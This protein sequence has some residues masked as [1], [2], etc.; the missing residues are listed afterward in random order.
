MTTTEDLPS[1]AATPASTPGL[2]SLARDPSHNPADHIAA[3]TYER[4]TEATGKRTRP[5]GIRLTNQLGITVK[6][7]AVMLGRRF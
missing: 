1:R 6:K 5:P 4:A 2:P 3:I 7:K